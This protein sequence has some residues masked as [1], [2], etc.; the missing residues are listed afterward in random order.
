MDKDNS[1]RVG[2]ITDQQNDMIKV[3]FDAWS[4]NW[5]EVF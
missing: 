2:K 5:D 3:E 1:W 4:H